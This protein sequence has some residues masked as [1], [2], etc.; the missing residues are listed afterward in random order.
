MLTGRLFRRPRPVTFVN[1]RV[2]RP[3]QTFASAVRV[4]RGRIAGLDLA[5]SRG[6]LVIDCGG[7]LVLPGLINA[8]DHLELNSFGR[9]KWRERYEH[10]SGWFADFQPRFA[11]DPALVT[12]H[13][14]TLG[15]RLFVGALKNLLC[16]VTTACH[17]NPVYRVLRRRFPVRVV[18]RFGWSHSLAIDGPRVTASYRRTPRDW[19][20]LIHAA[21]GTD[22]EASAEFG[23]LEALGCTGPNTVLVHGV[24]L[25]PSDRRR[26]IERGCSLVW[27]PSS[28]WFLLGATA[29]VREFSQSGRL[30]LGS[31]SRLSGDGDLLDEL[32][33]AG[34]TS[35]VTSRDL[36][37]AVTTDAARALRIG[38]AGALVSGAPADLMMV[39]DGHANSLDSLTD[40]RRADVRVVMAGGLPVVADPDLSDLFA[41]TG[42]EATGVG[43]DGRDKLLR[44][45]LVERA[46]ASVIREPGL[47]VGS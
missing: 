47:E 36:V 44:A 15:D 27:C 3:D 24:G 29:E 34:R 5:P 40:S 39:P 11:T 42:T 43:L 21:E 25:S 1:A 19:P 4:E 30:A 32:R 45:R 23:Q 33:A 37:R 12:N 20:W 7:A 26:A 17:H 2:L 31:D 38:G 9:L 10:A 28:N 35:L 18:T 16:G 8:H 41:A 13:P 14:S 22:A 46:R 6:D